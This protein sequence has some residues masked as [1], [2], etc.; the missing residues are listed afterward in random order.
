MVS[1]RF[2]LEC[3]L[4][5]GADAVGAGHQHGF[6]VLLRH[7]EQ[8]AETAD[9]GQHAF[10]QRAFGEGLDVL[11]ELVAGVDVY[12]GIAIGKRSGGGA[13]GFQVELPQ[14]SG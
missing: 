10:P 5:F 1:W 8:G 3:E 2:G 11:D 14:S 6:A 13:F 7:L 9:A 4:Q 12:A